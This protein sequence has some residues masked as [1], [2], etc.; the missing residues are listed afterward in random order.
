MGEFAVTEE[1]RQH[2]KGTRCERLVDEW[3]LPLSKR[4]PPYV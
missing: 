4:F 3:L 1:L 2:G